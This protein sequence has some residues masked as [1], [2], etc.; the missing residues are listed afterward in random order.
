MKYVGETARSG[1]ERWGDHMRDA[2]NKRADSHIYKHWQ[3]EHDGRETEFQFQ[4]IK[5]FS[6]PWTDRCRKL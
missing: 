2:G 5:F 3:N 6:S 1:S 4:I